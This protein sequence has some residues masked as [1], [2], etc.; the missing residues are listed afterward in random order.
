MFISC[1]VPTYIGSF[2]YT[3]NC[4]KPSAY[5]ISFNLHNKP[6]KQVLVLSSIYRFVHTLKGRIVDWRF[7]G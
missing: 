5:I 1:G 4:V 7:R 6:V 2:L 3:G